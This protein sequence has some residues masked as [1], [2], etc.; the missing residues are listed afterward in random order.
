MQPQSSLKAAWRKSFATKLRL[1]LAAAITAALLV[2]FFSAGV[3]SCT[4]RDVVGLDPPSKQ[5]V[6][7]CFNRHLLRE[8]GIILSSSRNPGAPEAG[9]AGS[10]VMEQL[11]GRVP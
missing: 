2:T 6:S 7:I 4:R 5:V 1:R 10:V 3:R 11:C 9:M 8:P